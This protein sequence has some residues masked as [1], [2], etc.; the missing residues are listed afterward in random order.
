VRADGT[1]DH[2]GNQA[3][4]WVPIRVT[5]DAGAAPPTHLRVT[6]DG[7][8]AN[9]PR[10]VRLH[11]FDPARPDQRAEV[12]PGALV[13]FRPGWVFEAEFLGGSATQLAVDGVRVPAR[14]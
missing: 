7:G 3:A 6:T 5:F 11:Y 2:E 4:Y 9:N 13:P 8:P 1:R 12:R 10:A 14:R